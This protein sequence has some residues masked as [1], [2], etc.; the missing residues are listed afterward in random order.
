M[1]TSGMNSCVTNINNLGFDSIWSGSAYEA[2]SQQLTDT[3]NKL[4]QCISDLNDF[5]VILTKRDEYIQICTTLS[6]LYSQRADC[7]NR[8]SED[9]D[10]YGCGNCSSL[11]T[12]IGEYETKRKELRKKI[13]GLLSKF[14]GIDA[15][16][17][18]PAD[19]SVI[20]DDVRIL[21]DLD[22]LVN[23]CASG[24]LRGTSG[25][26]GLFQM[27]NQTDEFGNIIPNSGEKYVNEQIALIVSQCRNEREIAVNVGLLLTKLAADKGYYL[28]YENNGAQGGVDGWIEQVPGTNLYTY[29]PDDDNNFDT[30][31]VYNKDYNN[32]TQMQEGMD[33]CALVSYLVNV[34]TAADPTVPNPEGYAWQ[35]VGGV[36]SFGTPIDISQAKPG[37]VFVNGDD[38]SGTGHT[39]MIAAIEE[40]P[41]N[42]GYGK[43]T[44]VE[45][46][47]LKSAL[48]VNVYSYY[49]GEDG[50]IIMNGKPT[51]IINYDSVY[52]GEEISSK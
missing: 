19:L 15:E 26:Y 4:N 48:S 46:G 23:V 51:T 39:G 42:P 34:A 8:H 21:I 11:S 5:D 49:P 12:Q 36:G 22:A 43:I 52:S 50:K 20:S 35:G 32:I 47:G 6:D 29:H 18:P 7:Q 41:N 33:C 25:N 3:M 1:D 16:I 9:Q 40:D 24:N 45:S 30:S 27:Y 2:Q 10:K 17:L 31:I 37:D 28:T 13:I 44:I 38:S 14:V